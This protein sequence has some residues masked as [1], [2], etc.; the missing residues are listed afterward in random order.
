VV[1]L[2]VR[3][4]K[5]T[6]LEYSELDPEVANQFNNANIGIHAFRRT[7]IE[8]AVDK[9]LPYH[10][11]SKELEQLDEDFGVVKKLTLK[12]ELFYFVIFQYAP[13]FVTLQVA[14]YE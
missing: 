2:A 9:S 1:R 14:R 4:G 12:L 8:N 7:L 6:V 5:D 13:S 10:L 3:R 11:A